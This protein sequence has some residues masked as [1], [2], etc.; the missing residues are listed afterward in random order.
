MLRELASIK[1]MVEDTYKAIAGDLSL[2]HKGL[3][4]RVEHNEATIAQEASE[5]RESVKRVHDRVDSMRDEWTKW[6]WF[7]AGLSAGFGAAGGIGASWLIERIP[8]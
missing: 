8:G 3:A 6:K 4:Q 2:G 7:V 5:R 1:E